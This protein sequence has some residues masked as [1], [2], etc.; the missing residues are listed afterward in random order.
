M[1][2]PKDFA[3][4][5]KHAR[6]LRGLTQGELADLSGFCASAISHFERGKR[7]PTLSNFISLI[8]ALNVSPDFLLGLSDDVCI[9]RRTSLAFDTRI[10]SMNS[11]DISLLFAIADM[12]T[13]RSGAK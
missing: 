8:T 4:R 9:A 11:S 5:I 3:S 1:N 13:A 12:L 2:V 10:E 6:E 7:E